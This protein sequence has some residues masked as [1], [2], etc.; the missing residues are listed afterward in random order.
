MKIDMAKAYDCLSWVSIR[1]TLQRTCILGSLINF[2]MKIL[3]EGETTILWNGK[4]TVSFKPTRGVKQGDPLSPYIFVLCLERL[5]Q[6]IQSFINQNK[7]KPIEV[8]KG[9]STFSHIYFTDDFVLFGEASQ[10]Q[11]Q[12]ILGCMAEFSRASSQVISKEKSKI[13]FSRNVPLEDRH[14]I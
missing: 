5:S 10:A 1:D 14:A 3:T 2:I 9:G 8:I 7:W 6:L 4:L 13:Y 12:C 11:A